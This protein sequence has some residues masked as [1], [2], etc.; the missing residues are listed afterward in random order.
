[1]GS[2]SEDILSR[3]ELEVVKDHAKADAYHQLRA[4]LIIIIQECKENSKYALGMCINAWCI[5]K[6]IKLKSAAYSR[7]GE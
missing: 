6:E 4:E 2:L 7:E 5:E 3:S 1:M